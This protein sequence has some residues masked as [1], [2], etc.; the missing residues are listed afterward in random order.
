MKILCHLLLLPFFCF[1]CSCTTHNYTK[2]YFLGEKSFLF[3]GE[4]S[5]DNNISPRYSRWDKPESL[6]SVVVTIANGMYAEWMIAGRKI[7]EN[8]FQVSVDTTANGITITKETLPDKKF[9][10]PVYFPNNFPVVK[11][12]FYFNGENSRENPFYRETHYWGD[13]YSYYECDYVYV[14][15]PIN[16]SGTERD[17]GWNFAQY[18]IF[19]VRKEINHYD[20]KFSKPGWYKIIKYAE[21]KLNNNPE[22]ASTKNNYF[23]FNYK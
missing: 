23:Y 2:N 7:S 21:K 14:A 8:K 10:I 12:I 6:D 13:H 19:G 5:S 22:F 4:L 16:L 20:L 15:E 1:F 18:L 17:E 3:E 11:L 9:P